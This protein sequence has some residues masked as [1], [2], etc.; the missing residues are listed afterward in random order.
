MTRPPPRSTLSPSPPLSRSRWHSPPPDDKGPSP[1]LVWAA[2]AAQRRID[3]RIAA[4]A[5]RIRDDPAAMISSQQ[6]AA[7]AGVSESRFLHLF[8]GELGTSLRRYRL[9]VRLTHAGTALA[10]GGNPHTAAV[11]SRFCSP[12]S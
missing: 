4:A 2:P 7:E 6:L 1:W 10:A 11:E 12:A 8:R 3:Q 5:H 9:W